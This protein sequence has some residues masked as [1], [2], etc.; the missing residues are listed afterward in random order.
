MDR[1][2]T[3]VRFGVQGHIH[4]EQWNV[5][6]DVLYSQPIGMNFLVGSMTTFNAF[7]TGKLPSFNVATLDADSLIPIE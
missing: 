4:K 6:R 7:N 2:Q 3:V 5:L 1:F